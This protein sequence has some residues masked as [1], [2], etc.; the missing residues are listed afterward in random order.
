MTKHNKGWGYELWVANSALYCGKILHINAG[1]KMSWHYHKVKDETF[2][3]ISGHVVLFY[4][5]SD[6]IGL[7]E[8]VNLNPGDSFHIPPLMK[9]CLYSPWE[10]S[11]IAEFST[12][13][14][15]NDS[16][17]IIKGD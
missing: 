6:S 16:Y 11:E 17:R 3:C 10:D 7:S 13:H 9:H 1:K 2:Y 12:Q 4:G 8:I 15:E 5:S 14:F